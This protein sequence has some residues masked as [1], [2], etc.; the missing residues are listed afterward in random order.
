MVVSMSVSRVFITLLGLLASIGFVVGCAAKKYDGAE[1]IPLQGKVTVDGRPLDAGTISFV[2]IDV[3]SGRPSGGS[4]LGGEYNVAEAMG[5]NAGSY[6]VEIHWQKSTG[7]KTRAIDSDEMIEQRAEGLPAKYHKNSEL[8]AEV[9][10]DKTV[11]DFD[12]LTK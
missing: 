11:F 4:I 10:P 5:A 1:R 6:R 12:L 7:K 8:K 3:N 9:A 2:P